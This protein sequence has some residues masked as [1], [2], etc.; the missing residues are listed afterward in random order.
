[1]GDSMPDMVTRPTPTKL[2]SP[3]P[4]SPLPIHYSLFMSSIPSRCGAGAATIH[5]HI[6][7]LIVHTSLDSVP[8]ILLPVP[9]HP[10]PPS[11]EHRC[12]PH[13]LPKPPTYFFILHH[14]QASSSLLPSGPRKGLLYALYSSPAF[15]KRKPQY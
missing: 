5:Y 8:R 11:P 9:H 6:Y 12:R 4:Y 14:I 13:L 2:Q 1:M 7:R 15:T 10:R 3:I